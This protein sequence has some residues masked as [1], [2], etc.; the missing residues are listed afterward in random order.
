MA[1]WF[2]ALLAVSIMWTV[3]SAQDAARRYARYESVPNAVYECNMS[4]AEV[5]QYGLFAV[6]QWELWC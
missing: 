4:R 5:E 1:N 2:L 3:C 6:E